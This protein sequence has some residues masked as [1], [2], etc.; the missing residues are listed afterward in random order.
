V[1]VF[2]AVE[3]GFSVLRCKACG[4]GRT[5]PVLAAAE[6]GRYYPQ[7]YYGKENVRFN[8]LLELMTRRFQVRRASLLK[9]CAPAGRVLDVGC[10]RGFLL[11]FLQEHGYEPYGVEMSDNAAWHARH[12]LG[13]E[14]STSD[15]VNNSPPWKPFNA[16]VFWHSLEHFAD[17]DVAVAKAREIMNRGAVLAV[18]LPNFDSLQARLFG[19]H[20]F[21]LD[22]PRHYTHFGTAS[23]RALLKR[24]GF[25]IVRLDHLCWEQN[26]YGWLQSFYNAL[27]IRHNLLYELLKSEIA[28]CVSKY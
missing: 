22:V 12:R 24:Q 15:F 19:R 4:L 5:W 8:P 25:R 2:D 14:I 6:V 10:G 26:P 23:L 9:R 27:G 1:K 18:A 11:K 3:P 16:V 13:L 17:A 28:L 21:H 7:T 20:W